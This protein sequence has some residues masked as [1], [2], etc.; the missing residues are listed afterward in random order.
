MY[1]FFV[2][3]GC[4][5]GIFLHLF[6]FFIFSVFHDRLFLVG[7]LI[8]F[9]FFVGGCVF[10]L[11]FLGVFVVGGVFGFWCVLWRVNFFFV[12]GGGCYFSILL[13]FFR[14]VVFFVILRVLFLSGVFV[15]FIFLFFRGGRI[16]FLFLFFLAPK[17]FAHIQLE[18]KTF[19][20]F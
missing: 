10:F 2:I 16:F 8:Y 19:N 4:F 3:W 20:F 12:F 5:G 11:L 14:R 7:R 17:T 9:L 6:F 13:Y 18:S 15:F 1:L